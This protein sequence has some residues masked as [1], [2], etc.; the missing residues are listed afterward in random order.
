M[1]SVHAEKDVAEWRAVADHVQERVETLLIDAGLSQQIITYARGLGGYHRV[2]HCCAA[3]IKD[4]ETRIR[5]GSNFCIHM[6]GLKFLDDIID[7][8]APVQSRELVFGSAICDFATQ[9]L[10]TVSPLSNPLADFEKQWIPIWK[11]VLAEPVNPAQ[12]LV[13][14]EQ[15][16]RRK[17][18]NWLSRYTDVTANLLCDAQLKPVLHRIFE[19]FGVIYQISDDLRDFQAGTDDDA[20]LVVLIDGSAQK[21]QEALA[22]LEDY[23][24]TFRLGMK[25]HPPALDFAWRVERV[26]E[27]AE[28]ALRGMVDAATHRPTAPAYS[29]TD[30][31]A[32]GSGL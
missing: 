28:E 13:E 20:N 8:D 5:V 9:E 4:P 6:I 17:A 12:N 24:A 30:L 22:L 14:W 11:T 27:T 15:L 19:S 16:A 23:V 18:G 1:T 29:A 3:W 7:D 32:A 31:P 26:I 10:L 2:P 21:A 25:T